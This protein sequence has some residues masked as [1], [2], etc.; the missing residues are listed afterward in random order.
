MDLVKKC[1]KYQEH[2]NI[3]HLLAAPFQ[4]IQS[5]YPF[6]RWGMD[7]VGKLPRALGQREYLIVA[8][9]YFSKWV[10][11]EGLSKISE[12][13]V[14]KF[15]WKNIVCRFSIPMAFVMDNGTLFQGAKFRQWCEKLKIK[16]Y[17]TSVATP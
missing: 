1:K 10:K 14:M 13:E 16:Q 15:V 8:V 3:T 17:Y 9:D 11:A 2:A 12:K 4:P 6:D 5:P 7:I